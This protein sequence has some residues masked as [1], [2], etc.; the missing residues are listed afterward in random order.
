M[1][2]LSDWLSSVM[3]NQVE[4][5]V[6]DFVIPNLHIH[7]DACD[8][9]CHLNFQANVKRVID[10]KFGTDSPITCLC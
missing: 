9:E 6:I 7:S 2:A 3:D 10:E 8:E 5:E 1:S 4:G